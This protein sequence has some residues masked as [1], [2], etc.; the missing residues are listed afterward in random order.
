MVQVKPGEGCSFLGLTME[1]VALQKAHN[2]IDLSLLLEESEEDLRSLFSSTQRY[3]SFLIPKRSGGLRKIDAPVGITRRI[4]RKLKPVLELAYKPHPSCHGFLAGRSI[5][6]GA[7][8]HLGNRSFINLDIE[9]FF[10]SIVFRRVRGLLLSRPF[11]FNWFVANVFAQA[12]THGGLL[13]AGGITSPLLSSLICSGLDVRLSSLAGRFG[14][15]YTRY[16]DDM[17]LSFPRPLDSLRPLVQP[18][19]SGFVLGSV[20]PQIIEEEGFRI[21]AGKTSFKQRPCRVIVTGLVLSHRINVKRDWIRSLE[22]KIYAIEKFGF[23]GVAKSDYPER[24]VGQVVLS[25]KRSIQGRIAFLSMVR[26]AKDWIVADLAH[27]FNLLHGERR[28]FVPDE[29]E[30]SVASR[31]SRAL[32]VVTVAKN[33]ASPV[34][35]FEHNGTGFFVGGGRIVTAFHVVE[36]FEQGIFVRN[37]KN[38]TQVYKCKVI[39]KCQTRDLALLELSEANHGLSRISLKVANIAPSAGNVRS[40][41]YPDYLVGNRAACQLHTINQARIVSGVEYLIPSG[42]IRGGLSGAPVLNDRLAVIAVVH[43]EAMP[44]GRPNELIS[45]KEIQAFL[46]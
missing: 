40:W 28:F 5:V 38:F 44:G 21:N 26:G 24:D 17:T 23:N 29:E 8:V 42:T 12:M 37:E 30:V 15:H 33:Q 41:G 13:P 3:R 27:R 7:S 2:Y 4:Q 11:E 32:V 36:G 43:R 35:D 14:G 10:P 25:L 20:L 46:G 1:I 6:T 19:E 45:A 22:S 39:K 31:V 34:T 18:T 16:A 9:D